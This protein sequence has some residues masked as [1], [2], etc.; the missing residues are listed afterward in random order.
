ME[1]REIRRAMRSTRRAV[2][3]EEKSR[4][5]AHIAQALL[6]RGDVRAAIASR[7]PVCVYLATADEIDL[8]PFIAAVRS[9]GGRLAA[10]RWNGSSYSLSLLEGPLRE[11][12]RSIPEPAED[13]PVSPAEI[14]LWITPGLAFTA[15][16]DR[17]GYGGGWYDRFFAAAA[18]DAPRLG[19]AYPFQIVSALPAEPHDV[20]L[21]DVLAAPEER[22]IGFFDS[23]VGGLS[24]WRAVVKLLPCEST[25]YISD[26]AN[27]PYGGR[28]P[29][30][31]RAFARRHVRTL[32]ARG[33]KMVVVAC[34]TATAAAVDDLRETWPDVPFI[35]LE[36]AVKPAACLSK[37]HVVGVL[38]TKG[39]FQ[40]RLYRE[41]SARF[42]V[43]ARVVTCTAEEFVPL[44]ERGEL[45]G[46]ATEAVVSARIAP[47]LEA[48]ADPIVLGCTHFPFL[49]PVIERVVAGRAAVIDPSAAVARQ[50]RRILSE[51]GLLRSPGSPPARRFETTGDAARLSGFLE[52]ME[53]NA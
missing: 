23:G 14:S 28:P 44:V 38:A 40:G 42:A 50:V 35:G 39:T 32:L 17:L 24:V 19:V 33:A 36:P 26:A 9:R 4:H 6:E 2:P 34:N 29:E 18:P 45:D 31:I 21:T 13:N 27:C 51:R 10:P 20:P 53:R 37:T 41:T 12:P 15:S 22:A 46:P 25:D 16:G 7:A 8:A 5:E 52:R 30:E 47:L 11:G 3:P 1:K 48:G 49:R 43:G